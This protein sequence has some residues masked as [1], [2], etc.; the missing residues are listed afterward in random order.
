MAG[1]AVWAGIKCGRSAVDLY[2]NL[3]QLTCSAV[4]PLQRPAASWP[5]EIRNSSSS[6][7]I[8]Y[9]PLTGA[10]GA[11][12]HREMLSDILAWATVMLLMITPTI[13]MWKPRTDVP[14][15]EASPIPKYSVLSDRKEPSG[16]VEINGNLYCSSSTRAYINT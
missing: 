9:G 6:S 13:S 5:A 2:S 3:R 7:R 10:G 14:P 15:H 12:H 8:F 4:S 11:V 16:N 1:D